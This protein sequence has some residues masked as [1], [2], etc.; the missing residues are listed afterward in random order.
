MAPIGRTSTAKRGYPTEVREGAD[1]RGLASRTLIPEEYGGPA[2]AFFSRCRGV[3]EEVQRRAATCAACHAQMYTMGSG[4]AARQC[5]QKQRYLP[6]IAS[7]S[8]TPAGLRRPEPSSGTDNLGAAH[9][10]AVKKKQQPYVVNGQEGLDRAVPSSSDLMLLSARTHAQ[11]A[12]PEGTEGLS[13]FLVDMRKALGRASRSS[14]R[15]MMNHH[16]TEVFFDDMESAENADRRRGQAF[17]NILGGDECRTHP[18]RRRNHRRL[19]AGSS[20]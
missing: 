17:R 6:G 13:V 12:G 9:Q 11:G 14:H 10:T 4:P 8:F 2:S 19:R 18:D 1:R 16:T 20:R 15:T 7:A 5:E 3:L